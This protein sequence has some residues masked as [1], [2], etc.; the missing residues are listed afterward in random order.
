M[1][2]VSLS[3]SLSLSES[4]GPISMTFF[5]EEISRKKE[6]VNILR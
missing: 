3:L 4:G 5:R 1:L 6:V 2:A